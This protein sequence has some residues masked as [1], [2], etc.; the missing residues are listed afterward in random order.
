MKMAQHLFKSVLGMITNIQFMLLLFPI[1][2]S[3]R[4][5]KSKQKP[6]ASQKPVLRRVGNLV[7]FPNISSFRYHYRHSDFII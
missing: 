4:D 2:D 1:P 6:P 5:E 3:N 7:L